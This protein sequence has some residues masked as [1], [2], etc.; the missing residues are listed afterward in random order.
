MVTNFY[1]YLF[2][3]QSS[4]I[5]ILA[6]VY[7]PYMPHPFFTKLKY[8]EIWFQSHKDRYNSN[9]MQS[10]SMKT[11]NSINISKISQFEAAIRGSLIPLMYESG[12]LMH[13]CSFRLF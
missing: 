9:Y 11:K 8:N 10:C 5:H 4:R 6:H 13:L 3:P 12:N 2:S 7:L 1:N